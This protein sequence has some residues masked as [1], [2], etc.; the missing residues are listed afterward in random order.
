MLAF[1]HTPKDVAETLSLILCLSL[2]PANKGKD[3]FMLNRSD[4]IIWDRACESYIILDFTQLKMYE[5]QGITI[6]L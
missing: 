6:S 3:M 5:D 2:F 4:V 1:S